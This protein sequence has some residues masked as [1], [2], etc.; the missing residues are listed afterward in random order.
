MENTENKFRFPLNFEWCWAGDG[1]EFNEEIIDGYVFV[2]LEHIDIEIQLSHSNFTK[3]FEDVHTL[4]N[5][6]RDKANVT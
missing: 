6:L 1:F 5:Y 2:C 3:L 4:T